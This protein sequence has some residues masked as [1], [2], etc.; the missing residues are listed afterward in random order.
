M[1]D[2]KTPTLLQS[3]NQASFTRKWIGYKSKTAEHS[4]VIPQQKAKCLWNK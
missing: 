3:C 1:K 4:N 2:V